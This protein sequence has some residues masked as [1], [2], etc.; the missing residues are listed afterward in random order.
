M[1][2]LIRVLFFT[3]CARKNSSSNSMYDV[4]IYLAQMFALLYTVC[5]FLSPVATFTLILILAVRS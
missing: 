1:S 3:M 5:S 4:V 2:Y